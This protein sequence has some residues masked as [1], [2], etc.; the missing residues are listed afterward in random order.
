MP[1]PMDTIP[2]HL[3]HHRA[4]MPFECDPHDRMHRWLISIGRTGSTG[5]RVGDHRE[6]VLPVMRQRRVQQRARSQSLSRPQGGL[7]RRGTLHAEG[8]VKSFPRGANPI[9]APT[10]FTP[11]RHSAPRARERRCSAAHAAKNA[12]SSYH[13]GRRHNTAATCSFSS[14]SC[15]YNQ[16]LIR[17]EDRALAHWSKGVR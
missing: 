13:H 10:R 9:V 4:R 15:G 2:A 5:M 3:G 16:S 6:T 12:K 1:R 8:P 7:Y 14:I 17:L 11:T